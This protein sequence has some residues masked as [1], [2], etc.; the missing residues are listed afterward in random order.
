MNT[1]ALFSQEVSASYSLAE[2]LETIATTA[3]GGYLLVFLVLGLIWGILEVFNVIFR[4]K[5]T[6]TFTKEET[7]PKVAAPAEAMPDEKEIV[8]AISA[9]IAAHT[10]KPLSSF[11]VISFRKKK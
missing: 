11:R 4:K 10:D 6:P 9:A 3:V 7:V 8:A 2:K 1:F 5:K